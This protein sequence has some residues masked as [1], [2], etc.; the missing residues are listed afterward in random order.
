MTF[1]R[2]NAFK[3]LEVKLRE[4]E[5]N[6]REIQQRINIANGCLF[7][8]KPVFNFKFVSLKTKILLYKVIY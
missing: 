2:T 5:D 7:D 6:H 1:E 4:D 3:Y 8:L